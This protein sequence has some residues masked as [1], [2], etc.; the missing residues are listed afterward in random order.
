MNCSL[1]ALLLDLSGFDLNLTMLFKLSI[2]EMTYFHYVKIKPAFRKK[3]HPWVH[4]I[5]LCP[6]LDEKQAMSKHSP[7]S[8]TTQQLFTPADRPLLTFTDRHNVQSTSNHI[9][10][11]PLYCWKQASRRGRQAR[12]E[13]S[14]MKGDISTQ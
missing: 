10:R 14:M 1:L 2:Q 9:Y 7:L 12:G 13:S 5:P 6:V 8:V 11:C 4:Y 3:R